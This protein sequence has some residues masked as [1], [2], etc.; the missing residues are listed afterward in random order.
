MGAGLGG[1][2]PG[3]LGV[4]ALVLSCGVFLARGDY[5]ITLPVLA[6]GAVGSWF[7]ARR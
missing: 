2:R 4:P 3:L 7:I 6:A 1:G 5:L